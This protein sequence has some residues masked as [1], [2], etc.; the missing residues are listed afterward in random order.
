M[1]LKLKIIGE[2]KKEQQEKSI[3]YLKSF[4]LNKK[5]DLLHEEEKNLITFIIFSEINQNE[6]VDI[7]K[8]IFLF[9]KTIVC[10]EYVFLN[11]EN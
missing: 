7:N 10:K 2:N 11:I 4:L 5:Y 1:I 6:I 3:N 9:L 8:K